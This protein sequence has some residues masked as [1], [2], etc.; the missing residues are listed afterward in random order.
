MRTAFVDAVSEVFRQDSRA[1]LLLGDIGAFAFK[2]LLQEHPQRALNLGI[3]EQAMIGVGAGMA[4]KGVI[5]TMHTIAPFLV[6][7]AFEQIKVDFGYQKLP[8]NFVS[9]GASFDYSKLGATHH[10]PADVGILSNIP[11][12]RIFVPGHSAEFSHSYMSHW[13]SGNLNYFRLSENANDSPEILE[14]SEVRVVERGSNGV[15]VVVGPMRD[16]VTE[17]AAGLGLEIHYLNSWDSGSPLSLDT[18]FPGRKIAIVEP[19]YSGP[20]LNCLHRQITSA[21]CEVLQLGVPKRFIHSYGEF[22]D[23]LREAELDAR[24]IRA[25]FEEFFT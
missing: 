2:R 12:A 16:I 3:L 5:P 13:S 10:C 24:S 9:V 19:Y 25:Y 14:F 11:G 8:G 20:L 17:A 4:S 15:V 21:A 22:D 23:L 6:E 7:R 1:S 18:G